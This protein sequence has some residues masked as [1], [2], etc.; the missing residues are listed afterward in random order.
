MD[1]Y[2]NCKSFIMG[3]ESLVDLGYLMY[4]RIVLQVLQNCKL[5]DTERIFR[6]LEFVAE[7]ENKGAMWS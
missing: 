4:L 7:E 1:L 2:C 6:M 3:R 5:I